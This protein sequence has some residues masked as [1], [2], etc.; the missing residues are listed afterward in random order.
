MFLHGWMALCYLCIGGWPFISYIVFSTPVI[1]FIS[2][3]SD[4]ANIAQVV[5]ITVK[6]VISHPRKMLALIGIVEF[7]YSLLR[8]LLV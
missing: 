3:A 4:L 6:G 7:E 5:L 8:P 1:L 2:F